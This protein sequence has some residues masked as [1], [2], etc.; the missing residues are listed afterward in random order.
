MFPIIVGLFLGG[1][2]HGLYIAKYGTFEVQ[3]C[4]CLSSSLLGFVSNWRQ[5]LSVGHGTVLD[6]DCRNELWHYSIVRDRIRPWHWIFV[7]TSDNDCAE[8]RSHSR[9]CTTML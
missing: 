2:G 5:L 7:P 6:H 9:S 8:L 1:P 4:V 3:A